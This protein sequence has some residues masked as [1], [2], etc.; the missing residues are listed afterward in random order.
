MSSPTSELR[1][2]LVRAGA[3]AGKT[4]GLV[5]K[6]VEVF[7]LFAGRGEVPRII[8]T[9]FTR[10]ATQELKERL[11]TKAC[12]LRDPKLLQFVSDP[13]R[14]Q[15]STIHGL[16]NV[17]LKQVG[18]LAG[19]DAGF[20]ILNPSEAQQIARTCLREVLIDHPEGLSWL[21]TYG[22][23]R[24]LGLCRSFEQRLREWG[25]LR[26]APLEQIEALAAEEFAVW[27]VKLR[28]QADEILESIDEKGWQDFAL[29]LKTFA[30]NWQG[31]AFED[32]PSKP[33]RS[34]KQIDLEAWH[35]KVEDLFKDLKKQ[36]ALPVWRKDLWPSMAEEWSGFQPLGEAF[37][38]RFAK[39][40][41]Q[42]GRL[43]MTDLELKTLEI[44]RE[45]PFLASVFSENWDFWMID[46]YQDTSP[47]QVAC[48]QA[49]IG[50]GKRYRVGDPQQSIYLFRGAEVRVFEEAQVETE[51]L[52]GEIL[53]LRTNYRSK[54]DLL[55]FVNEFM[56]SV[57][58][59]FMR[60]QPRPEEVPPRTCAV[61]LKAGDRDGEMRAILL[62]VEELLKLGARL[63][64]ICVLGRTHRTLIQV[65]KALKA[66]GYPTHVHAARGFQQRRE[67]QDA[68]AIWKF[69]NNPHDNL[70]LLTLLRSP[71]FYI[72]DEQ[73]SEWMRGKPRSLWIFLNHQNEVPVSVQTLRRALERV[74]AVGFAQA[75][76][77]TLCRT[78]F[79]D[80]ALLNDPAGRKESNLWKLIVRARR[81]MQEGGSSPLEL[82]ADGGEDPLESN[83]GD[84][85][86]A[87]EPN[88]INLMTIHAAKGL[89][90][91]HVILPGLGEAP[92]QSDTARL[93]VTDAGF[94]FPVWSESENGFISSPLDYLAMK[95]K[96]QR[97]TEEFD[98]L[99]YVAV[100]RAKSTLT[101]T[102]SSLDRGSW[103][104]RSPWFSLQEGVHARER[105]SFEMRDVG[106]LEPVKYQ[107]DARARQAPRERWISSESAGDRQSV[108]DL[109]EGSRKKHVEGDVLQRWRSQSVGLEVHRALE[110]LKYKELPEDL[111]TPSVRYVLGLNDPPMTELI[112]AGHV[113]WGFQVKAGA[114]VI[115]GQMDLWAELG[116]KIYVID[117][118]TGSTR[119]MEDAFKQLSLYAWVLRRFGHK[120]PIEMIVLYPLREKSESREFGEDLFLFWESE[121][122]RS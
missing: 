106:L 94:S 87:Q 29:T 12:D 68:L 32:L 57:S 36:M 17:F 47:V 101:L 41:D 111:Q 39:V 31:G 104:S 83:E 61:L 117:Y 44:L 7:E 25:S 66:S 88:C 122:S 105:F 38:Q 109:V 53:H 120:K 42:T 51:G 113:E 108:T 8:L 3:G 107:A 27:R 85:A 43:E 78:G 118:K 62:R 23:E 54:P 11:I 55:N 71:W 4:R 21:E 96:R 81:L 110:S 58:S 20:Q 13:S 22:F 46:E 9:T 2:T 34:K 80:L 74:D 33:R 115:E 1:H 30:A 73:L 121:F 40:K 24:L 114:H 45:H 99:L 49:L 14:L 84:A 77:E 5:E 100:T 102:W 52:L 16:L 76:E 103:A 48:L 19:L 6:I 35:E 91:E 95:A 64:D 65:A 56:L 50:E 70:N 119:G 18:H 90:F 26:P 60:M 37:V 98:R 28:E 82:L 112:K 93:A 63:E 10:K 59:T 72:A 92:Q 75:F 67:V 69:L 79:I 116:D 86:S 97:E 89:E 15:I